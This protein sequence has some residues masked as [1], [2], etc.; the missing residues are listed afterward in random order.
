MR[1]RPDIQVCVAFLYTRVKSPT[2]QNY[3]KVWWVISYLKET[4]QLP[5]AIGADN[6]GTLTWKIDVSIAVHPYYKSHTGAY[7]ISGQ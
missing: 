6:N 4:V 2:E 1:A 5:L 3:R 7:L